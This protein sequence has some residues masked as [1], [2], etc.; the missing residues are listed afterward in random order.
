MHPPNMTTMNRTHTPTTHTRTRAMYPLFKYIML[1]YT[2]TTVRKT[3]YT[4]H[5]YGIV[6][7]QSADEPRSTNRRDT[8]NGGSGGGG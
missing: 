4:R 7:L 2:Y 1:F 5:V 8:Q 6:H 3:T